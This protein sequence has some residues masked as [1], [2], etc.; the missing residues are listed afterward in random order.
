[1]FASDCRQDREFRRVVGVSRAGWNRMRPELLTRE[2][3]R[4]LAGGRSFE[5]GEDYATTG[6]VGTL[7]WDES[8]IRAG[9]QGTERYRVRLEL[10]GDVLRAG[11]NT[12]SRGRDR[13]ELV[14]ALLWERDHAEAWREAREGGCSRNLWLALARARERHHPADA[15]EVYLAQIEPAIRAG[16]NHTHAGA[17]EWLEKVQA[18][19]ARLEQEDAFDELVRDVRERH[20]AKRN[21]IKRLDERGWSRS[22]AKRAVHS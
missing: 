1:M 3:L 9:V 20:R 16:D 2:T 11:G 7:Q 18:L 13:S 14:A 19:F 5:R 6:A 22:S 17:V 15:L 10:A 8:S 4:R 21:L 12:A